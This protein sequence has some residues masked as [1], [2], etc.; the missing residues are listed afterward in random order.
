MS[1]QKGTY[2]FASLSSGQALGQD[3]TSTKLEIY[4][5]A[6][7]AVPPTWE[8]V[9]VE[10]G[11]YNLWQAGQQARVNQTGNIY[12]TPAKVVP[13]EWSILRVVPPLGEK[14]NHYIISLVGGES[15]QSWFI[16][17]PGASDQDKKTPVIISESAT[18]LEIKL[19]SPEASQMMRDRLVA[20]TEFTAELATQFL[21]LL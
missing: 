6:A 7:G 18:L 8:V 5:L 1:L 9:K 14:T 3:P 10:N 11:N 20:I 21:W 2:I 12:L 13:L 16:P 19:V 4:V 17:Y 15:Q